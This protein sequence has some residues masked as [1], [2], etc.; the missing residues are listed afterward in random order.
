[1]HRA[2]TVSRP[3]QDFVEAT[4]VVVGHRR[5]RN[6][7]RMNHIEDRRA[8]VNGGD[9]G[10]R[11][12][13]P[14]ASGG[15]TSIPGTVQPVLDAQS[16]IDTLGLGNAIAVLR[17]K[18]AFP[19]E[20]FAL[21][22]RPL[23]DG[24]A[25]L[26]QMLPVSRSGRFG[27]LGGQLSR[28]LATAIRGLDRRRS[29]ILPRGAAPEV[30]GAQAHRWTYAVFVAALLRDLPQVSQGMRVWMQMGTG[31]PCAWRPA[32]GPMRGCGALGYRIETL[33]ADAPSVEVDPATALRLF[34]RCVPAPIQDWLRED[35]ALMAELL[36]CLSGLADPVGVIRE[37]V[38]CDLARS[39]LAPT[40]AVSPAPRIPAATSVAVVRV[41]AAQ[42]VTTVDSP[43][44]LEEVSPVESALAGQFM[45]WLRQGVQGGVLPVNA[46]DALVHVVAEGLLLASPRIFRE[47]A[48][49][50]GGSE[51]LFDAARRVQRE[52]LREGW[53][54]RAD[55]GL[56]IFCYEKGR[57]ARGRS[58]RE[59][60]RINGIVIREP[61]RFIQP[62]PAIDPALVRVVDGVGASHS[63]SPSP[64]DRS[65]DDLSTRS[66]AASGA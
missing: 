36:A 64:L 31:I 35:Q 20:V 1:M 58:D 51:P 65:V 10:D 7:G 62:L 9:F 23:I 42:M 49:Q 29:Q 33:P 43:E 34:E 38:A 54:L 41:P 59:T 44:F 30:I 16:L 5:A 56:S 4:I 15:A 6:T 3:N 24:H 50:I 19:P 37:L 61:Q 46:P 13:V 52:V 21:A 11:M 17:I 48:K 14:I 25:E 2:S 57:Y 55:R 22:A 27:Q 53:H 47:F 40:P 32:A 26:V 45:A 63:S 60:T 28:A 18:L 8:P 39:A 66:P 12:G